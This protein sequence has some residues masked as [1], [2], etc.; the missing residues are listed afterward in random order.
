[1]AEVTELDDGAAAGYWRDVVRVARA[2]EG[3]FNPMKLNL[4]TL[5]NWVPHLHTLMSC[6]AT[7]TILL[8]EVRSHG[9]PCSPTSRRLRA[10]SPARR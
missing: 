3:Q 2:I 5:G 6:P 8:P 1:V 10:C 9:M 7:W 4:M